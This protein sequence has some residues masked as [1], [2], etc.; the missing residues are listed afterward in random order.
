LSRKLERLSVLNLIVTNECCYALG[1]GPNKVN[2]TS[3][4]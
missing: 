2:T 1:Q 4:V 3:L